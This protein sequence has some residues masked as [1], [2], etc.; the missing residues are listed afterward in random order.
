MISSTRSLSRKTENHHTPLPYSRTNRRHCGAYSSAIFIH[1]YRNRFYVRFFLP[2]LFHF[3]FLKKKK[4]EA[5]RGGSSKSVDHWRSMCSSKKHKEARATKGR[6]RNWV[7][8]VSECFVHASSPTPPLKPLSV[9]SHITL[10]IGKGCVTSQQEHAWVTWNLIQRRNGFLQNL[11]SD[12]AIRFHRF[13]SFCRCYFYR[14]NN[15]RLPKIELELHCRIS[16][17]PSLRESYWHKV[18]RF[19]LRFHTMGLNPMFSSIQLQ[20]ESDPLDRNFLRRWFELSRSG[21]EDRHCNADHTV[22]LFA[23]RGVEEL[24]VYWRHACYS[25]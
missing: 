4:A 2:V 18:E 12:T 1:V 16:A 8:N 19:A 7:W 5:G 6:H 10:M 20:H 11:F 23:D 9:V 13:L 25:R 24:E 21:Q 17:R 3:F 15:W 14:G 22:S